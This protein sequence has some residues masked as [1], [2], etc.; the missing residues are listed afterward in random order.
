M[1]ANVE[2]RTIA[3]LADALGPVKEAVTGTLKFLDPGSERTVASKIESE[4]LSRLTVAQRALDEAQT[5][6]NLFKSQTGLVELLAEQLLLILQCT[7]IK[8][9]TFSGTYGEVLTKLGQDMQ[10]GAPYASNSTMSGIMLVSN[11]PAGF[12]ALKGLTG[13]DF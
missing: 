2:H 11:A 9:V 3:K 13:L 1:S 10:T 4:L 6:Y 5:Q 8:M 12:R 7:D